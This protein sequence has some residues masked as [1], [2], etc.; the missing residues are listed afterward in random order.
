MSRILKG[1]KRARCE[2]GSVTNTRIFNKSAVL[3]P[4]SSILENMR[5]DEALSRAFALGVVLFTLATMALISASSQVTLNRTR[6]DLQALSLQVTRHAEQIGKAGNASLTG[7]SAQQIQQLEQR[8]ASLEQEVEQG[9]SD[10]SDAV[11]AANMLRLDVEDLKM[12]EHIYLDR[13]IAMHNEIGELKKKIQ[14][15]GRNL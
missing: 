2:R 4:I 13:Y 15:E 3:N 9:L 12:S 11:I 1:L 5:A 14:T 6:Q 8:F 10:S 7:V